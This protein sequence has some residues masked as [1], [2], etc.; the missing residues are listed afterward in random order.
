MIRRRFLQSAAWLMAGH[1]LRVSPLLPPLDLDGW[2]TAHCA[3]CGY[4]F[5]AA[6]PNRWSLDVPPGEPPYI[7]CSV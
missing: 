1:T 7:E 5:P 2:Y 4:L 6:D 3:S